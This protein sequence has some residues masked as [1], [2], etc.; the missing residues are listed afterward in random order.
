MLGS[1]RRVGISEKAMARTPRSALRLVSAAA[2]STSHSGMMQSGMLHAARWRAPL[3]DH[4]VVVGLDA[5][6]GQLLVLGLVE[7]LAA[8]AGEGREGQ[9][10]VGVVERQVLDPLVP[11]PAALAHVVVGDGRHGHL[12]AVEDDVALVVERGRGLGGWPRT[13]CARR[14][15]RRRSTRR[16]PH[17]PSGSSCMS[18]LA[19]ERCL[20]PPHFL[21]LDLGAPLP[22]LLRAAR[23]A[24]RGAARRHGRQR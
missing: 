4:P 12:G 14:S 10:A 23:S 2:S 24:T 3:L 15:V 19:P 22:V 11:V 1:L 18:Y 9:R 6:Q 13:S 17:S 21:S 5:G 8:E 16:S 20:K 7:G